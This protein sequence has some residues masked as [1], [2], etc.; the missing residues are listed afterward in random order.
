[1][2]RS[3]VQLRHVRLAAVAVRKWFLQRR[4]GIQLDRSVNISMTSRFVSRKRGAISVGA[5][6][7]VAF[8]TL[9]ITHDRRSAED[10]PIAIGRR[11][12]IGGGSIICPGVTVGD[13]C[14]VAAGSVVTSDVPPRSIVGGNP[15]ALLKSEIRVGPYGRLEGSDERSRSLPW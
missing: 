11:C 12:F 2:A 6:T 9:I 4:L 14:I 10:R 8:K 7:Y 3:L 5:E 13:D 15:A 1:M